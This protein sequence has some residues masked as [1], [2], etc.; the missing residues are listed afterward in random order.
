MDGTEIRLAGFDSD[1]DPSGEE[2]IDSRALYHACRGEK[3]ES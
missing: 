1:T 2:K 3:K